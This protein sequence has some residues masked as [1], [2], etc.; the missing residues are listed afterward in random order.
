MPVVSPSYDRPED[1]GRWACNWRGFF[2]PCILPVASGR[3]SARTRER[4]GSLSGWKKEENMA[5]VTLEVPDDLLEK[6]SAGGEEPAQVLRL[7]AAFSLCSR[8]GLTTSQAARL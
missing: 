1:H 7:A 5:S 4:I 8:A 3:R 2:P 6:L